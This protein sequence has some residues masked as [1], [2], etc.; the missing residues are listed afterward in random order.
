MNKN[1]IEGRLAHPPTS[2][3]PFLLLGHGGRAGTTQRNPGLSHGGKCGG[4]AGNAMPE[5]HVAKQPGGC[6]LHS[7]WQA[8]YAFL[9]GEPERSGDSLPSRVFHLRR[10]I[11]RRKCRGKSAEAIVVSSEPGAGRGPFK[12][13]IPEDSMSRRAEPMRNNPTAWRGSDPMKPDGEGALH[14]ATMGSMGEFSALERVRITS[15]IGR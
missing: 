10:Q 4:C 6:R 9:P 15:R 12:L 8:T 13:R 1:R 11:P 7:R 3:I 2:T 14:L 5:R